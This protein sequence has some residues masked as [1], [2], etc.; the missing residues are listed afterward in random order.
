MK[1]KK[2]ILEGIGSDNPSIG[3]SISALELTLLMGTL[4]LPLTVVK[5]IIG[6]IILVNS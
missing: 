2:W 4:V 6:Q 1:S 5:I 3:C